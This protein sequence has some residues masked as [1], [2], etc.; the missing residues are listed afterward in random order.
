MEDLINAVVV[1]SGFSVFGVALDRWCKAI[2]CSLNTYQ[3]LSQLVSSSAVEDFVDEMVE[4]GGLSLWR[5]VG[6]GRGF[7][8]TEIVHACDAWLCVGECLE[9]IKVLQDHGDFLALSMG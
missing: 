5:R 3:S 2:Q 4:I 1:A 7:V 8:D 6:G 9:D